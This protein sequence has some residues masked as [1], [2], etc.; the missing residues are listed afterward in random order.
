MHAAVEELQQHLREIG[1]NAGATGREGVRAEEQHRAD[2]ID[3]ERVAHAGG[4]ASDEVA[5]QRAQLAD[6]DADGREIAEAGVDAVDRRFAR[7]ELRDELRGLRHASLRRAIERRGR[8]ATG[9]REHVGDA[10]VRAGQSQRWQLVGL[11]QVLPI[12]G[13]ELGVV[14]RGPDRPAVVL[15][16]DLAYDAG[17]HA[18]HQR[19]RRRGETLREH[20][21]R[22]DDRCAR[23]RCSRQ[24]APRR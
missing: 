6:R 17:G 16:A 14:A 22:A 11:L 9:D 10:E 2:D 12:P 8:A 15:V 24:R 7:G 3:R 13:G 4:V 19:A 23:R 1:P 20:G 18:E 5:L 21:A